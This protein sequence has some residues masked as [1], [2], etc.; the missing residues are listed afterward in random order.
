MTT[1]PE[2]L[3]IVARAL[4]KHMYDSEYDDLTPAG[5]SWLNLAAQAAIDAHTEATK[6]DRV[7]SANW[8]RGG[9]HSGVVRLVY[10]SEG[11]TRRHTS[12][13]QSG[14]AAC[15]NLVALLGGDIKPIDAPMEIEPRPS[16]QEGE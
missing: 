1:N 3:E 14:D 5:I 9:G 11:E 4:S 12:F 6:P 7:V 15:Q 13:L 2:T 10:Y 8:W 16:G